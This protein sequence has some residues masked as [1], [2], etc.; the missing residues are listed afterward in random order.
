MTFYGF[1]MAIPKLLYLLR[2][3]DCGDNPLLS[4]FDNTLRSVKTSGL[5]HHCLWEMEA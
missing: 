1:F 2:T 3:S 5:K 4:E